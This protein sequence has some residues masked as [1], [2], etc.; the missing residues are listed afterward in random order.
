MKRIFLTLLFLVILSGCKEQIEPVIDDK[1]DDILPIVEVEDCSLGTDLQ[2]QLCLEFDSVNLLGHDIIYDFGFYENDISNINWMSVFY[3]YSDYYNQLAAFDTEGYLLYSFDDE[4]FVD[5]EKLRLTL[6]Y[7]DGVHDTKSRMMFIEVRDSRLEFKENGEAV[8]TVIG[9]FEY[10]ID[11]VR[12]IIDTHED[13]S[14]VFFRERTDYYKEVYTKFFVYRTS[15]HYASDEVFV[16]VEQMDIGLKVYIKRTVLDVEFEVDVFYVLHNKLIETPN[17]LVDPIE[18]EGVYQLLY[19]QDDFIYEVTSIELETTTQN[20]Y[21]GLIVK[22]AEGTI[23]FEE[24]ILLEES[25][26]DY[27]ITSDDFDYV[28]TISRSGTE[29]VFIILSSDGYMSYY[30]F[31]ID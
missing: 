4:D 22:N 17:F 19:T 15:G 30:G 9:G 6:T 24:T 13:G 23:V 14:Y 2:N 12:F 3:Q 28:I 10:V 26:E 25:G 5:G 18:F 1:E 27:I 29:K 11:G 8:N 7:D 20:M 21:V 16:E 31:I